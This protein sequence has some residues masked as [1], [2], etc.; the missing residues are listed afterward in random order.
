MKIIRVFPRKTNCTPTDGLAFVGNP[1]LDR[2]VADEVHVSC[3]FTWDIKQAKYLALAW[4]QYYPVVKLGGVAFDMQPNGFTP[5]MYVKA[6]ITFTTRG[7]NNQCPFCLVSKREG[8]LRQ[9]NDFPAG[10]IIQD[11]NILQAD[12]SHWDKVISMLK[13]QRAIEFIG[14]L[15]ARLVTD[16]K[17]DDIRGLRVR[18]VFLASDY[19][20]AIKPLTKAVKK[21]KLSINKTRCYVLIAYNGETI[22]EARERLEAVYRAGAMPFAQLYQPPDRWIGYSPEWKKLQWIFSRPAATKSVMGGTK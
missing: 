3:T 6:G 10:N 15:D 18:Q 7:C 20:D 1:P 13:A 17:A 16:R 22:P 2:P 12:Q 11:N 14:G 21:L 8:K 4:H 9:Y 19:K 5:G